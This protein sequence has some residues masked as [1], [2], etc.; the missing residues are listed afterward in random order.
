MP[1]NCTSAATRSWL[2]GSSVKLPGLT[3]TSAA[4]NSQSPSSTSV[5]ECSRLFLSTPQPIVVLPCGSQSMS[6]TFRCVAASDAARL[7]AVVVLPTPPFWFAT[8]MT[9]FME[10][11]RI[12]QPAVSDAYPGP[13]PQ[14]REVEQES[15]FFVRVRELDEVA[16]LFEARHVQRVNGHDLPAAELFREFILGIAPLH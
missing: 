12:Q 10:R 3:A 5:I 15:D 1:I 11:L 6:S 14:Q 13:L 7:T 16:F 2:P 8:A 4:F 9:R